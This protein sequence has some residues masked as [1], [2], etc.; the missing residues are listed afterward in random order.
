MCGQNKN[1]TFLG[2]TNN[3]GI[4]VLIPALNASKTIS[5]SI[6]SA[7]LFSP[8]GSEILVYLDGGK[9]ESRMLDLMVRLGLVKIFQGTVTK[10]PA[11]AMN[12][13]IENASRNLVA[14]LD[15]DDI[16]LP[17]CHR[18]S[19]K[20]INSLKADIV[21]SNAIYFGSRLKA[22][23]FLPQVPFSIKCYEV[24]IFLT[25]KNP[26]VQSTML[27]RKDGLIRA[28]GYKDGIA[29]DYELWLRCQIAGI[30]MVRLARYGVLYRL[31][32]GQLTDSDTYVKSVLDRVE[33]SQLQERVVQSMGEKLETFDLPAIQA[34]NRNRLSKTKFGFRLERIL[35]KNAK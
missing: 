6:V 13:L 32:Q 28:G 17:G 12:V 21:F 34:L 31:H 10:G 3:T 2:N 29:E 5:A 18:K 8:K 14:R 25:F 19:V 30:R 24:P 20:L 7:W 27:A 16:M 35:S 1:D 26:F 4:S 15:A 33:I 9:T 11:N 22:L 23:P